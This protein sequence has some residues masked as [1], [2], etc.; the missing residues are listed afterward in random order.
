MRDITREES[1][2][3]EDASMS[4]GEVGLVGG[5]GEWED[6]REK[7]GGGGKGITMTTTVQISEEHVAK[8]ASTRQQVERDLEKGGQARGFKWNFDREGKDRR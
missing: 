4:Q 3:R 6:Q 8:S 5:R 2:E 1:W 7:D